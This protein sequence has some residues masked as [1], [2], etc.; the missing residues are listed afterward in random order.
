M[1][2]AA[3]REIFAAR[4]EQRAKLIRTALESAIEPVELEIVDQ[5]WAHRRHDGASDGRGHFAVRVVSAR[6]DQLKR[7][8]RHRLVF[9]A[10][11]D[12]M[13][14]D[15]HALTIEALTPSESTLADDQKD[16]T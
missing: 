11:G 7:L 10:L 15:I 5:S 14:S 8:A 2:D 6:F 4:G 1:S 3:D 16:L 13:T 9:D 12:L